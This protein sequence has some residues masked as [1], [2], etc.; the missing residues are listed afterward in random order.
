MHKE[1]TCTR[2]PNGCR[3]QV[4]Y[5]KDRITE[6]SGNQCPRG[7]PHAQSEIYDPRRIITS[8]VCTR[9]Q[10]L[11]MVPV[12][13]SK[14]IAVKNIP[15]AMQEIH[16]FILDHPVQSGDVLIQDFTEPG[17]ELIVTRSCT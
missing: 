9:K 8:T 16:K 10:Q 14:P 6:I 4:T 13:T 5:D 7:I 2:C 17:I 11:P 1:I 15:L 12:R 3:L